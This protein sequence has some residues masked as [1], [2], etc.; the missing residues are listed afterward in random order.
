MNLLEKRSVVVKENPTSDR[1]RVLANLLRND[2]L[3]YRVI[4]HN[5]VDIVKHDESLVVDAVLALTNEKRIASAEV[6]ELE[7]QDALVAVRCASNLRTKSVLIAALSD[8]IKQA[9]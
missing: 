2:C 5:V 7:Y 1:V 8:V 3:A 4:L 9:W 6:S